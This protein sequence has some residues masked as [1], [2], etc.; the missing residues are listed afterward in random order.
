MATILDM[1]LVSGTNTEKAQKHI[2]MDNRLFEL[3][4]IGTR[5]KIR[6]SEI[7]M[8]G[9]TPYKLF[10]LGKQARQFQVAGFYYPLGTGK[11]SSS[12]ANIYNR[13]AELADK[14]WLSGLIDSSEVRPPANYYPG[15]FHEAA[16]RIYDITM[17]TSNLGR[18]LITDVDFDMDEFFRLFNVNGVAPQRVRFTINMLE[19]DDSPGMSVSKTVREGL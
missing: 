8:A 16:G 10:N 2:R 14:N 3:T 9:S 6:H 5:K 15:E 19:T 7:P 12:I 11:T 13:Y 1:T 17:G 4:G 18:F